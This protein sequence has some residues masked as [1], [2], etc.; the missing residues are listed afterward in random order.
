[1]N[2][3]EVFAVICDIIDDPHGT[4]HAKAIRIFDAFGK[5][6]PEAGSGN[7][8]PKVINYNSHLVRKVGRQKVQATP[9]QRATAREILRKMGMI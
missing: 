9:E 4:T 1:M 2:R 8:R 6:S 5:L 7:I 3:K